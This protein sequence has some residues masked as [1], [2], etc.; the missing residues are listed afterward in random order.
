MS[1]ITVKIDGTE[2]ALDDF[3]LGEL[4]WL[5]EYIGKPLNDPAALNSM[6]TA[7]AFVYLI[8]RRE[9][10]EFSLDEA[11]KL[12]LSVIDASDDDEPAA[13]KRPPKRAAR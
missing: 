11:R 2:H 5:E 8:K 7:V 10:P 9:N 12:K 4:E 6:K 3:E 13:K 1:D